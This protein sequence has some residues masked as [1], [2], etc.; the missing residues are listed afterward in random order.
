MLNTSHL[1]PDTLGLVNH[2]H[3]LLSEAI[4]VTFFVAWLT[5]LIVYIQAQRRQRVRWIPVGQYNGKYIL[6]ESNHSLNQE[7]RYYNG[8][9]IYPSHEEICEYARTFDGMPINSFVPQ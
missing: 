4:A 9:W 7:S 6:Y 3:N 5:G 2:H 1:D 8:R